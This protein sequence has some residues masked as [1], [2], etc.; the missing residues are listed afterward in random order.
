MY[1]NNRT[2]RPNMNSRKR[3]I[4]AGTVM[5]ISLTLSG[6]GNAA[7]SGSSDANAAVGGSITY[8]FWGN[9]ARA[10]KVNS[11][12][13]L[14]QQK[15]PNSQVTAEVADY[16]SYIERL[17]VR[18]AGGQ[19][20]CVI[21]TQ[22]T[23]YSTYANKNVLMP[24][25]DFIRN[26]KIQTSNIPQ[27]VLDTGKIDGK[28]YM[29]PTGTFVRV[30]AYNADTVQSAGLQPPTNDMTW[31]EYAT[32]LKEL[33]KALPSGVYATEVEG[34]TMF[35]FTSW[36][37]GHGQQMFK[38]GKLGFSKELMQEWFQYWID[39]TNEG[40][41]VPTASIPDQVGA[42]ELTPL[43]QGK[44]AAG[45]RDIPQIAN[46]EKALKGANK[47][48]TIRYVSVPSEDSK[49]S[50][51][52]LGSNG[53]SIPATCNNPGTAAAFINFF[54]NDPQAGVAFQ[55]DNGILTNTEAQDA[56]LADKQTS[57]AVKKSVTILQD[58]TKS[59]DVTNTTYPDGLQSL[60]T[61][62][63]RQYQAAAFGQASVAQAVD[64]FFSKAATALK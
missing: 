18:A 28:Q 17:T 9:P 53:L 43:A 13:S 32:W 22:S 44:A 16:N 64:Q 42:L 34:P 49:Q 4:V 14:F 27:A 63:T 35:S 3:L 33:Q 8:S 7:P 36:V 62:L 58:L 45:T 59:G 37:I 47:P 25:D 38:D 48:S 15:E 52:V 29:I 2:C 61:E 30:V 10:E 57:D 23:F 41:T 46:T 39:L 55:S 51:N 11:V 56:L 31:E 20:P 19:L 26:G 60:S 50:T 5:G 6:C 12:I 40:V 21:G 24:L 54:A 1:R